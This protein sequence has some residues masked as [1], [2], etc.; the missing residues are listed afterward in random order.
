LGEESSDILLENNF[1]HN[2]SDKGVS[3]GQ[4]SSIF[5]QNNTFV[6]CTQGVAVKDLSTAE[7]DQNTFYNVGTPIACFEKN[8]GI[9][10]GMAFVTNSILS[11]SAESP[12]LVDEY[13]I[14]SLNNTLSDTEVIEGENNVFGHPHFTNPTQNDFHLN[15]NS[16]ALNAGLN[17]TGNVIDLGTKYYDYSAIPSLMISKIMYQPLDDAD[18]EFIHILNASN[19]I[20]ELTDYQISEAVDFTFPVAQ[21]APNEE[22]RVAKDA[23]LFPDFVGQIFTWTDG[24]LSNNGEAIRLSDAYGIIVDQ[25]IYS[26]EAPWSIEAAGTG[27]SLVLISAN[28][29]NHFAE[30]WEV[31]TV[32]SLD[33]LE[34]FSGINIFPNPSTGQVSISVNTHENYSLI[35]RDI[36]GREVLNTF[37]SRE[38]TLDLNE[39]E[40]G[41][42]FAS[43]KNEDGELVNGGKLILVE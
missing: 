16:L 20:I 14:L 27:A 35:L 40:K 15:P 37:V 4:L 43:I 41:I 6:N 39:L 24:K 18:A 5:M 26:P 32:V 1:I 8:V 33:E 23:A 31:E 17:E 3:V 28:L 42:Y 12:I 7:V 30:S 21:I 22:I 25:V 34:D 10:G 11:N 38:V 9:G 36:I 19:E 29:D 2:C 13:S